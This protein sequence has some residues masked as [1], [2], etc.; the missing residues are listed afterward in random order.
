MR[1]KLE[2]ILNNLEKSQSSIIGD[3]MFLN[4]FISINYL[5]QSIFSTITFYKDVISQK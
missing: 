4:E 2:Y 5:Q 3:Q 1:T